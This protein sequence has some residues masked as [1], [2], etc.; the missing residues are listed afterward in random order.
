[1]APSRWQVGDLESEARRAL[2]EGGF[3][4]ARLIEGRAV[5]VKAGPHLAN[6]TYMVMG[7]SALPEGFSTPAHEHE[8]EEFA[9]VLSGTGSIEIDD[10]AVI[11]RTGT[12]VVTPP[13]SRHVTHNSGDGPLVVLWFYA[14]PGSEARWLTE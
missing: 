7:V 3:G 2:A 9:L 6:S 8:A 4:E 5:A 11:V 12:V 13:G 10:S 14:P 1:V